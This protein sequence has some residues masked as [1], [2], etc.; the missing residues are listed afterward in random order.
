MVGKTS[1]PKGFSG[2]IGKSLDG[3][4]RKEVVEY[5]TIPSDLPDVNREDLSTGQKYMYDI[6]QAVVK[7]ECSPDLAHRNPGKISHSRWLTTANRLLSLYISEPS[8][9][10]N[11]VLLIH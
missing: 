8:P 6:H 4:N 9:S 1:A 5:E 2:Q 10:E 11:L 7:G 3:W